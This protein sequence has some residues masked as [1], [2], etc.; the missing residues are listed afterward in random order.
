MFD[1]WFTEISKLVLSEK[2]AVSRPNSTPNDIDPTA[3]DFGAG[4]VE[5]AILLALVH[6]RTFWFKP[7]ESPVIY[8]LTIVLVRSSLLI[9]IGRSNNSI[10]GGTFVGSRFRRSKE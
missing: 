9:L 6:P 3:P 4:P 7:A 10:N 2:P 5:Q 1:Y 8:P